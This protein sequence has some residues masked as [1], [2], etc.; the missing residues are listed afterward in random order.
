MVATPGFFRTMRIPVVSGRE[1]TDADTT[2]SKPVMIVN[3]AFARKYFPGEN[4]IGK[5]IK[6]GLGDGAVNAP[7]CEVVGVVGDV[8]RSGLK[9]NFTPQYYLPWTQAVITWP[10]LVIRTSTDPAAIAGALRT[11]VAALN[12]EVPVYQVRTMQETVYRAAAEPRFQT[13]LLTVFAAAALLLAALGL[14]AVLSYMVAQRIGEIGVRMALGAQ[15]GDILSLIL[16]RGMVLALGGVAIGLAASAVLTRELSALLYEVQ[17]LD[18]ATFVAVSAILLLVG[19]T[20]SVMP[21][22]HASRVDP[23]RALR[24]Q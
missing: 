4:A 14:Y 11:K 23:M 19:L 13:M 15:R 22:L 12:P 21:A 20:A 2:H 3:Q 18:P 6:S 10:T 7:M 24:D 17:P 9:E 8:K 16:G 5:H 1:F